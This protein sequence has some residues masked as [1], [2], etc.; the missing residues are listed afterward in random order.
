MQPRQDNNIKATPSLSPENVTQRVM[1]G[2][3][4]RRNLF[5]EKTFC[6]WRRNQGCA[7]GSS[8]AATKGETLVKKLT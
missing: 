5:E 3:F 2:E 1:D 4:R 8:I 7:Q 6:G